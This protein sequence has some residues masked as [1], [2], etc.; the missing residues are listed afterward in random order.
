MHVFK[1]VYVKYRKKLLWNYYDLYLQILSWRVIWGLG[2]MRD[3]PRYL[4]NTN[5]NSQ[6]WVSIFP[7]KKKNGSKNSQWPTKSQESYLCISICSSRAKQNRIGCC[8]LIKLRPSKG[9]PRKTEA[10]FLVV[11]K[12]M[13][14]CLSQFPHL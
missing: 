6:W 10:E 5:Q 4:D 3:W 13:N 14:I 11:F 8:A 1:I 7:E 2:R 12:P 9:W